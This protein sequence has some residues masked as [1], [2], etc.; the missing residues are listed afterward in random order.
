MAAKNIAQ[1]WVRIDLTV[2]PELTE[3]LADFMTGIGAEGVCQEA[4]MPLAEEAEE[5]L[6]YETLTAHFPL[7]DKENILVS[8]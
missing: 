4:L 1:R 7:E 2:D 8:L 5:A 6:R 3:A